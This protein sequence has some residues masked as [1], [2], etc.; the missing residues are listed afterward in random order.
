MDVGSSS[1]SSSRNT[2]PFILN[3]GT[4]MRLVVNI[5]PRPPHLWDR[6]PVHLAQEAACTA[7]PSGC[8]LEQKNSLVAAGIRKDRPAFLSNG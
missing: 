3:L 1:S 8:T 7:E 5:T 6:K 2:A 4:I